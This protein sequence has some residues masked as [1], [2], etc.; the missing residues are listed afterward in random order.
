MPEFYTWIVLL[1]NQSEEVGEKQLSDFGAR[2]GHISPLMHVAL[3]YKMT[4]RFF[5]N[6]FIPDT[7]KQKLWQSVKA[8]IY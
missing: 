3:S 2:E 1:I 6:L 8:E 5:S 4:V 7:G